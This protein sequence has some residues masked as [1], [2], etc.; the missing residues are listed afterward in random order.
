M[1]MIQFMDMWE[2]YYR[3][4]KN[5]E[6]GGPWVYIKTH[7]C[8]TRTDEGEIRRGINSHLQCAEIVSLSR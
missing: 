3:Y 4:R 6:Q 7:V 8:T 2:L 1:G 5:Y